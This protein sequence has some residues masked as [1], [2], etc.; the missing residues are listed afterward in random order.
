MSQEIELP[1][2][3]YATY[4]AVPPARVYETLTTAVGWDAA[5]A[6]G[7]LWRRPDHRREQQSHPGGQPL[8]PLCVS[9]DARRQ[10]DDHR[11]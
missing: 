5:P 4:I 2:I 3:H 11:L 9:V 8:A 1:P 7:R 10:H 6:L